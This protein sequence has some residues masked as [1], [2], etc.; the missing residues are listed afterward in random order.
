M[1]ILQQLAAVYA[2]ARTSVEHLPTAWYP[3]AVMS[4]L[5][6][7]FRIP[8]LVTPFYLLAYCLV[9]WAITA[10]VRKKS[11]DHAVTSKAFLG[12]KVTID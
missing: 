5:P 12:L 11:G 1:S 9:A 2:L 3:M 7:I 4:V 10:S 6:A 8:R